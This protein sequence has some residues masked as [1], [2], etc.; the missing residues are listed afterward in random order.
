M[1][2]T[3]KRH[4]RR[5]KE[6]KTNAGTNISSKPLEVI[7]MDGY[8]RDPYHENQDAFII[9]NITS[10]C[11]PPPKQTRERTTHY[12]SVKDTEVQKK[13]TVASKLKRINT[14]VDAA[15]LSKIIF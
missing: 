3:N 9:M 8:R 6:T 14:S 12:L 4:F 11:W 2:S 7:E 5:F 13:R 15:M 10:Q 1:E